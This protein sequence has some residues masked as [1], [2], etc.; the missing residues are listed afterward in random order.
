MKTQTP[1]LVEGVAAAVGLSNVLAVLAS[2]RKKPRL[3]HRTPIQVE[4]YL[5]AYEFMY[6]TPANKIDLGAWRY[7]R[8]DHY[9]QVK[10][11][12]MNHACGS[13]GCI[14]GWLSSIEHFKKQGLFYNPGTVGSIS[15]SML[16]RHQG[17]LLDSNSASQ[18]LFG[19]SSMF[20]GGDMG[21]VGKVQALERLRE[22][23]NRHT[24]LHDDQ[25]NILRAEERKLLPIY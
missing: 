18:V 7:F 24:I 23:M 5:V 4:N 11:E 21:I 9:R 13:V 8:N 17:M 2:V 3:T 12:E 16:M 20:T 15:S 1:E 22:G 10:D 25:N 19:T 14:G 6:L